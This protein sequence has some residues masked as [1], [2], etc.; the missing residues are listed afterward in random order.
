MRS[1]NSQDLK[2]IKTPDPDSQ[3]NPSEHDFDNEEGVFL[4]GWELNSVNG[5]RDIDPQSQQK[6]S[7]TRP[8]ERY[9]PLAFSIINF[10]T[11]F[12]ST[13]LSAAYQ[14]Q[15]IMEIG[16]CQECDLEIMPKEHP[17][18]FKVGS[19]ISMILAGFTFFRYYHYS[20]QRF[21]VPES[22]KHYY[23]LQINMGFGFLALCFLGLFGMGVDEQSILAKDAWIKRRKDFLILFIKKS[24]S[25]FL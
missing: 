1:S 18:F 6:F 24:A 22:R 21:S 12:V 19:V 5:L 16:F 14:W 15:K 17:F 20:K 10:F 7:E 11:L 23:L 25:F 4:R 13:A 8:K 2:W 9:I 3:K